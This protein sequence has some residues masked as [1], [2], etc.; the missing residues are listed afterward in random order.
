M[1]KKIEAIIREEKLDDVKEALRGIGI[2]GLNV[3]EVRGHGRQGGIVLNGRAGTYKVDLLPRVQVN[4]V[5]SE[6]NVEKTI[7]TIIEA[8]RTEQIGDGI[9]FIYPVEDVIR[10]RTGERGREALMYAGDIDTRSEKV[11]A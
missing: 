3:T 10:I 6:H 7:N 4:I 9:I 2:I 11:K 8:A 5:L 1:F